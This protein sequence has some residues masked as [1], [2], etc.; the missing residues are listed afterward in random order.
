MVRIH[1]PRPL[2][3][4]VIIELRRLKT[5][6]FQAPVRLCAQFC[7]LERTHGPEAG[8]NL[9]GLLR[10]GKRQLKTRQGPQRPG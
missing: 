5:S 2:I 1:S 6:V 9:D 4:S 3:P 8:R 7:A 10:C